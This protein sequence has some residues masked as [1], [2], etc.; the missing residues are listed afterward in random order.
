MNTKNRVNLVANL[1][2]LA[3]FLLVLASMFGAH[4]SD[5]LN[6]LHVVAGAIIFAVAL[7]HTVLHWKWITRVVFRSS[8]GLPK[9][10]RAHR[11][12]VIWLSI[13]F[14]LCGITGIVTALVQSQVL[15]VSGLSLEDVTWLHR[16][17]GMVVLVT[18]VVHVVQNWRWYT[19]AFKRMV[20]R[21]T[22]QKTSAAIEL[23]GA[24]K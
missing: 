20:I 22:G 21:R 4:N 5:G 10:A 23:Q 12:T 11:A 9:K 15:S 24:I 14:V 13:P 18:M 16:L 1:V 17:L 3:S 2:L 8:R 7:L 19:A 6:L